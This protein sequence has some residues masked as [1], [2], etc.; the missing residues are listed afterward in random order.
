MAGVLINSNSRHTMTLS[1]RS[2][3]FYEKNN[4]KTTCTLNSN[5]PTYKNSTWTPGSISTSTSSPS[6]SLPTQSTLTSTS[7]SSNP[8]TTRLLPISL[9]LNPKKI[10]TPTDTASITFNCPISHPINTEDMLP[11]GSAPPLLDWPPY[12]KSSKW[13]D[14]FAC[15]FYSQLKFT[16]IN[17]SMLGDFYLYLKMPVLHLDS[18]SSYFLSVISIN[19]S[20]YESLEFSI[21]R[22]IAFS[23]NELIFVSAFSWYSW[24]SFSSYLYSFLTDSTSCYSSLIRSLLLVSSAFFDIDKKVFRYFFPESSFCIVIFIQN[25]FKLFWNDSYQSIH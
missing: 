16:H 21:S 8:S 4:P 19:L 11:F 17:Q 7:K 24:Y 20:R 3:E 18:L 15:V 6:T 13:S 12:S 9:H 5:N 14:S 2:E 1:S 10:S 25:F 22:P 23:S